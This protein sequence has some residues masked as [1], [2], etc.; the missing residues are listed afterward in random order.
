VIKRLSFALR[1]TDG[2]RALTAATAPEFDAAV[3]VSAA[4]IHDN[5]ALA[6]FC[7]Q[8]RPSA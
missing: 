1:K 3:L 6:P 4:A 2:S 8:S 5:P 7:R